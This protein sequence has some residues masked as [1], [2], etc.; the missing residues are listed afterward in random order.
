MNDTVDLT[1]LAGTLSELAR[2][3]RLMRLQ[4]D[5]LASR[6]AGLDGRLSGLDGRIAGLEQSFH[7]LVGEVS[8]GFG[9]QQQQITRLE[10]RIDGVDAGLAA[11]RLDLASNTA[12]ILA[13]FAAKP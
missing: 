8:R 2:D 3:M 4:V 5:N 9:Q 12:Q 1:L 13:A 11:L 7:D 6:F 10:K